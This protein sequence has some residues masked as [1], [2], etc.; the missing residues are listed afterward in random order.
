MLICNDQIILKKFWKTRES[1]VRFDFN[2][3]TKKKKSQL[4]YLY[5]RQIRLKLTPHMSD[6]L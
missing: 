3:T 2:E 6:Y 4:L 1:R 5:L